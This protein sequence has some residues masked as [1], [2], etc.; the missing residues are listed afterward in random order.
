V[1]S[2]SDGTKLVAA[3]NGVAD[4]L[5]EG[6]IY[7]SGDS[8][9]TWKQGGI[10]SDYWSAVASSSDGTKMVAVVGSTDYDVG[11]Y[12]YTSASSGAYWK[13]TSAAGPIW[14]SVAS[15]SD[16]TNL[17]AGAY[18][19]NIYTSRDSGMTWTQ[20]AALQSCA[21]VASSSDGTKLV[22]VVTGGYIYTSSGPVP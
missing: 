17:V 12:I 4:N 20:Q 14:T 16:G 11:G 15:S 1:A 10:H 6:Y 19:R 18:Y 21:S 13:F 5:G 8:G 9:A 22:G 3:A 7:V 2:S